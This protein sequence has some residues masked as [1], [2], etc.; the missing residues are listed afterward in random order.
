MRTP[1]VGHKSMGVLSDPIS[2]RGYGDSAAKSSS[3]QLLLGQQI[4]I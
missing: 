4:T 3:W 1:G 2:G